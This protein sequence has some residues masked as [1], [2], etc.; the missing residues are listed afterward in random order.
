MNPIYAAPTARASSRKHLS[1]AIVGAAGAW[2]ALDG[3]V[4]LGFGLMLFDGLI[5]EWFGT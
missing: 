3:V 5:V 4:E 2:A 1:D